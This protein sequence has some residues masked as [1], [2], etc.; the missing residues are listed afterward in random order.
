M[1][2]REEGKGGRERREG[3]EG[4]VRRSWKEGKGA[5]AR[6]GGI[7]SPFQMLPL[8]ISPVI[9]TVHIIN[10]GLSTQVLSH[11]T[12]ENCEKNFKKL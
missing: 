7:Y 5:R 8:Q 1:R 4:G 2:A 12:A 11:N 3:K 9:L 10:E 6:E